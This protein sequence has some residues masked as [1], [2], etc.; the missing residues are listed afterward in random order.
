MNLPQGGNQGNNPAGN[1]R[2]NRTRLI[3][4]G[5]VLLFL[6]VIL[7]PRPSSDLDLEI[8]QVV[9][10]AQNG[11]VTEI[12]VRGDK[13]T[14]ITT[15]GQSFSSRKESSVSLLE[16]L[17]DREQRDPSFSLTVTPREARGLVVHHQQG[18]SSNGILLPPA[19]E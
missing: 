1:Q 10:M 8:S 5:A 17:A 15:E 4:I 6:A 7:F 16:F 19:S 18:T 11:Q 9:E 2:G 13:L 12:E 14:V 3:L